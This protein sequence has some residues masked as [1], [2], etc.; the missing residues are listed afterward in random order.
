VRNILASYVLTLAGLMATT[1][2]LWPIALLLRAVVRR[3]G[4]RR[5][6]ASPVPEA[7]ARWHLSRWAIAAA[8]LA[9]LL[10]FVLMAGLDSWLGNSAYRMT[11]VYGMTREMVA[12]LWTAIV[13]SVLAVCLAALAVLA[14]RRRWWG[15]WG[16]VYYSVVALSAV[17]FVVFL[18]QWNLLGFRY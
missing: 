6:I 18:M 17:L 1:F 14:W 15:R 2:T 12:L 10:V 11:L 4:V 9:G 13:F 16:R 7:P 5:R 3:F 8:M